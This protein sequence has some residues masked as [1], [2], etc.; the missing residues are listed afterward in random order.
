MQYKRDFKTLQRLLRATALLLKFVRT[1]KLLLK[2]DNWSQDELATQNIAVAETLWIKEIQRTLSKN[3]K[4]EI[5][6]KAVWHLHR[7]PRDNKVHM[8]LGRGRNTNFNEAPYFVGQRPPHHISDLQD[9]H[10]RVMHG[11]WSQPWLNWEQGFG[12]YRTDSL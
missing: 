2:G 6:E 5:C 9:S 7:W 1:V 3:P 12:L 8:T 10:K 4:F 11:V